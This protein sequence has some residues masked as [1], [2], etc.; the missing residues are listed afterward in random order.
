MP[1]TSVFNRKNNIVNLNA[2]VAQ[3]KVLLYLLLGGLLEEE[4]FLNPQ[5]F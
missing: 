1:H 2:D 5:I 4:I 3:S